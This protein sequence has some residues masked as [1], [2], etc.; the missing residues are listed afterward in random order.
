MLHRQVGGLLP[1]EDAIDIASRLPELVDEIRP[2][3]DQAAGSDEEAVPVDRRQLVPRRQLEDQ[4]AMPHH[5]TARRR[6]QTT[7]R[8]A[9]EGLDGPLDLAGLA[10][11]DRDHLDL[12]RRPHRLDPRRTATRATPGAISLSSSSHFPAK[13]NS[14]FVK[15]VALPP[16][17]AKLSTKPEPTGSLVMVNTIGTV[18]VACS[19]GPTL[20]VP[21]ASITSGASAANSAACLRISVASV[22]PQRV[23]M[24]RLRPMVQPNS[25]SACRNA[26]TRACQT[27]SSA[28]PGTSTPMCRT[29]SPCC[30][31]A[32]SGHAAAALPKRV[33]NS[34]RLMGLTPRPR[35]TG[36]V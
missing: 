10:H 34:R 24:R 19:N 20:E 5:H 25:A 27:E 1:L 21:P 30:A 13:L 8:R 22:V 32:A 18:R 23:S 12:E 17:R 29:R 16:G 4:I 7:I 14:Q 2:I 36:Q 31:R 35:I 3:G 33:M 26:P 9:R 28:T 11:V 6:D 15:P